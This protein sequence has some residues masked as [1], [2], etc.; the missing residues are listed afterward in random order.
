M[1]D[2][3]RSMSTA[4]TSTSN[5]EAAP[6]LTDNRVQFTR[7]SEE[8]FQEIL[9]E[10]AI[11]AE[12]HGHSRL[13]RSDVTFGSR[14]MLSRSRLDQIVHGGPIFLAIAI[15]AAIIFGVTLLDQSHFGSGAPDVFRGRLTV[16]AS[17]AMMILMLSGLAFSARRHLEGRTKT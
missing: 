6:G 14:R 4:P 5:R 12:R 15:F 7:S 1:M 10:A 13:D 8:A 3:R 11:N 16:S 9:S 2:Q 17:T